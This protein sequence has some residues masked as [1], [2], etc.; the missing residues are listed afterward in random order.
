MREQVREVTRV[1]DKGVMAIQPMRAVALW[2]GS[3]RW[4]FTLRWSRR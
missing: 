4:D 3:P 1:A 2:S